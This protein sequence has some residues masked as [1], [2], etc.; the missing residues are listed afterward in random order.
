M[1]N[2][3]KL[4]NN[5]PEFPNPKEIGEYSEFKEFLLKDFKK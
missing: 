4:I 5:K 1:P 2:S 3:L